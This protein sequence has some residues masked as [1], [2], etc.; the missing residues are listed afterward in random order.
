MN[1]NKSRLENKEYRNFL[2]KLQII[3]E[4]VEVMILKVFCVIQTLLLK[5]GKNRVKTILHLL[6]KTRR[7]L[8][9]F[10]VRWLLLFQWLL[11]KYQVMSG[12][13]VQQ[14]G[15]PLLELLHQLLMMSLIDLLVK[16]LICK[17]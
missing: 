1:P 17:L 7:I 14:K 3:E 13:I 15:K 9:L 5:K 16:K 10:I 2:I 11:I 4:F 6:V 8:Q 12:K